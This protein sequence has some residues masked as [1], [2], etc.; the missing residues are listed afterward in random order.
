MAKNFFLEINNGAIRSYKGSYEDYVEHMQ[1]RLAEDSPFQAEPEKA[2][3]TS[4]WKERKE[5][6]AAARKLS[7]Q[8][9]DLDKQLVL[10][11]KKKTELEEFLSQDTRW[12]RENHEQHKDLIKQIK[13]TE[14][15]WL[16]LQQK[17]EG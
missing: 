16:S 17:K 9:Q 1:R 15:E 7:K 3:K 4:S 8:I 12:S 2:K 14:D 10:Y 13:E 5:K 6:K 11:Q